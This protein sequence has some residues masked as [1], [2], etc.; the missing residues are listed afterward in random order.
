M[1][2]PPPANFSTWYSPPIMCSCLGIL[3][4]IAHPPDTH[5]IC[6]SQPPFWFY[7]QHKEHPPDHHSTKSLISYFHYKQNFKTNQAILNNFEF[8]SLHIFLTVVS[9]SVSP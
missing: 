6:Y 1:S 7:G 8:L 4:I 9:F 5:P 3:G 2:V